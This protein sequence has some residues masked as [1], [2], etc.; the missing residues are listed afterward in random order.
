MEITVTVECEDCDW[1]KTLTGIGPNGL[2]IDTAEEEAESFLR[3]HV[4]EV[5]RKPLEVRAR[6]TRREL[7]EALLWMMD[8]HQCC[9]D[10]YI[11]DLAMKEAEEEGWNDVA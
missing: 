9:G 4:R 8:E 2:G 3:H 7:V 10:P 11:Y 6:A 1:S 5:H